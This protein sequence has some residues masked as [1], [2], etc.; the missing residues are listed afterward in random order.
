[1]HKLKDKLKLDES[2]VINVLD[3]Q[4]AGSLGLVHGFEVE[5]E[6]KRRRIAFGTATEAET[7]SWV[8]HFNDLLDSYVARQRTRTMT[9]T[10]SEMPKQN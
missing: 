9:G 3:T 4:V 2:T 10:I 5:S 8:Q 7:T 1:M 6:M